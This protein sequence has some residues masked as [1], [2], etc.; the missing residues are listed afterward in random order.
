MNDEIDW[1]LKMNMDWNFWTKFCIIRKMG[2][3]T[4]FRTK[5]FDLKWKK[6]KKLRKFYHSDNEDGMIRDIFV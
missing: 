6:R 3:K 2:K 5:T 4:F 1:M